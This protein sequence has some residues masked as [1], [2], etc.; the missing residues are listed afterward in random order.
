[1]QKVRK[2]M[3]KAWDTINQIDTHVHSALS[4]Y[5]RA[6]GALTKLGKCNPTFQD[7][8]PDDL[9]MPGDFVEE[10]RIGQKSDTLPWFW[11]LDEGLSVEE[12]GEKMKHCKKN[13]QFPFGAAKY[14]HSLQDKLV[15]CKCKISEME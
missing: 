5:K 12:M 15:A 3:T 1:M 11:Q 6:R 10:N 9:K 7:I 13:T 4:T 14:S 2:K 8:T